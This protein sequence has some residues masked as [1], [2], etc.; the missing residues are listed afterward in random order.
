MFKKNRDNMKYRF[1]PVAFLGIVLIS[2]LGYL[3]IDVFFMPKSLKYE[4][5]AVFKR[6]VARFGFDSND[7]LNLW[8]EK[9]FKGKVL[10]SIKS[11][12]RQGYLNAYSNNSASSLL[13]WLKFSPKTQP[14]ISWKWK[15]VKFP[16]KKGGAVSDSKWVEKDDYAAR[17]YVIF[18]RFPFLRL[19][20]VEYVWA[21]DLPEGTVLTN[22]NFKNLKIVVVESGAGNLGKWV[23]E[24]RNLY[25]DFIKLFGS[26]PGNVGAIAVMTDAENTASTAEA[27]YDEIRVGYER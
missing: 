27:Q 24:E 20:C 1:S 12:R 10:Y 17:F 16:D 26:Q 4:D 6:S 23:F 2:S 19:Q 15:V 9:V 14:M 21:R 18:P 11:D 5:D 7:S 25:N 8:Q 13:Y 22:P 3:F